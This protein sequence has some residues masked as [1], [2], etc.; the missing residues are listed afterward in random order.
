VGKGKKMK[1][2]TDNVKFGGCSAKISAKE[3]Q[4]ILRNLPL[5]SCD[6]LISSLQNFDD[7]AVYKI[8]DQLAIVQ[9]VDFFPPLVDDPYLF[10]LIAANNALSDIYAMGG[11]PIFALN[12][13]G[14]PTCDFPL[15]VATEI[16]RGGQDQVVKSGAVIAGGHSIQ[17]P[18]I[19]YGLSVTG[20]I[21]PAQ[22]LTNGGAQSGDALVLTK[23]LGTGIAI[24]GYQSDNL[25]KDAS[26]SLLDNLT[27]L[28]DRPLTAIRNA[29]VKCVTDVT[30]FGLVGHLHEMA[31]ASNRSVRLYASALPI[32]PEVYELASQGFV[33]AAAYGNRNS[34]E[35]YVVFKE[36]IDLA[37]G[38]LLFDPQTA[39]GLLIAVAE[40]NL[41]VL[42]S[43]LNGT[44]TKIGEFIDGEAGLIEVMR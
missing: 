44:G 38:D 30:G 5:Q 22:M 16:L 37:L 18:E 25:S 4:T 1:S 11:K 40:K 23:P 26:K 24:L 42:L 9:T 20:L 36:D 28:N 2:L 19:L 3:L 34:F 43:A 17:T 21:D 10:G 6:Q 8:S 33:P 14:F 12:L 32:L 31:Q 35:Q 29:Q 13:L 7:A 41:S 39:G 27:S 15:A